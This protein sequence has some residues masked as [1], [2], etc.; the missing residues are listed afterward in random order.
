M[1]RPPSFA[2]R[3]LSFVAAVDLGATSGRV[4]VFGLESGS[5]T[6]DE[7]HRFANQ[8]TWV[9]DRLI[10]DFEYLFSETVIG[11]KKAAGKYRITSSGVDSWAVD[12][13]V[14]DQAGKLL[15]PVY[16]YRDPKH[17]SG[18][19]TFYRRMSWPEHYSIAGIQKLALN[20]VYQLTAEAES[21]RI[22]DGY[23]VLLVP[24]LIAFKAT[25]HV[26]CEVT[27]ASHTAML[28]ATSHKWSQKISEAAQVPV[29][30]MAEVTQP[31]T[32]LGAWRD[33]E[34]ESLPLVAVASHDTGS[35]FVAVPFSAAKKCLVVNLGTWALVGT[36]LPHPILNDS[37][38]EANFTNEVG[39]G[40]TTRFLK[41]VTGM[42]LLEQVRAEMLT[43]GQVASIE[44]LLVEMQSA[45]AFSAWINPD[46]P[47]FGPP[48]DMIARIVSNATG[49]TP[50]NRGEFV[51]CVL[52]SLI[53]RVA[54]RIR[55]LSDI[56]DTEY[57]E[58]VAVG[59]GSRMAVVCQW[60]AD[61]TQIPVVTGP[62]EA[63]ALGNAIVQWLANGDLTSIAEARTLVR[64]MSN[65]RDYQPTDTQDRWLPLIAQMP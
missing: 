42:W 54:Q 37:A 34:L 4:I 16:A 43:D 2:N 41:N 1:W 46:D 10:W 28:D 45:P 9:N 57:E 29:R 20:T 56:T 62:T 63:T 19:E 15:G 32:R 3:T 48:G 64:T 18:L 50:Q 44:D 40:Q 24:D 31:G 59:G 35:A 61:A 14:I 47:V 23:K 17:E 49:Q 11:L 38:R 39:Y 7:I 26:G 36:E 12:Y 8:P 33:R 53:A 13:G 6:S 65:S 27:N 5:I 21:E 60:L 30:L 51:R 22:R 55:L 25:G 52:E 58:I